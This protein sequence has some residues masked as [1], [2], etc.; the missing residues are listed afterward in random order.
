M[1]FK[2]IIVFYSQSHTKHINSLCGHG[3]ELLITEV[4]GKYNYHLTLKG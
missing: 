2:E 3:V 1:M 4:S